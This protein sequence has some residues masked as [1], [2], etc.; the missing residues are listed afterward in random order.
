M[1]DNKEYW[2]Y[3][4]PSDEDIDRHYNTHLKQNNA[5]LW[6]L[7]NSK[8]NKYIQHAVNTT[9]DA[10]D[11]SLR[12]FMTMMGYFKENLKEQ[13]QNVPYLPR[14]T[15]NGTTITVSF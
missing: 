7:V 8:F 6:D 10:T 14:Y 2:E 15:S 5:S 13:F 9:V 4:S 12:A 3:V 1:G 11:L